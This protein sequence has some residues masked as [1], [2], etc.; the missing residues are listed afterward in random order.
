MVNPF[1]E[2]YA[3]YFIG[4]RNDILCRFPGPQQSLISPTPL[5]RKIARKLIHKALTMLR[6][7]D[8][9]LA[10]SLKMAFISSGYETTL[11]N[12]S[13]EY[14]LGSKDFREI[15]KSNNLIVLTGPLFRVK[16]QD[17]VQKNARTIRDYFEPVAPIR[18]TVDR[19]IHYARQRGSMIVGVH[20]RRGDYKFFVN[21]RF[22]Y[23]H[24]QYAAIIRNV[25]NML[26]GQSPVFI[27]TSNEP[28]PEIHYYGLNAIAVN[29]SPMED[30]Y[31][32]SN[33]DY[34]IGPPSTFSAWA[35]FYG[36][37]PRYTISDPQQKPLIGD[38][39]IG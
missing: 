25:R 34:L 31:T 29:C 15:A 20:I 11:T 21:G 17:W 30:L 3:K 27:L 18:S 12:A 4:T 19:N 13:G 1:F 32:L 35:S 26:E 22:F 9:F 38:F 23:S 7:P 14:D 33:C 2:E 24:D 6:H 37:V 28:I 16:T 5:G 8:S 36:S 10:R 39:R